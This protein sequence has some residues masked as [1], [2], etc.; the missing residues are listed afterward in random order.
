M[1]I[2]VTGAA[3]F[4]GSHLCERLLEE[5]ASVTGLDNLDPFYARE[6]KEE[7]LGILENHGGFTFHESDIR[8]PDM[9]GIVGSAKPDMIVHLAA[10]AGVRPSIE[11]PEKYIS[12]NVSGTYNLLDAARI[13][14]VGSFIF[15]SSSSVYGGNTK[16]PFSET[17]GV[18]NPVSPY[19]A[20]KKAGEL[21]CHTYHH[22]YGMDITCLRL[23]TVYGPRQRPEM[24]IYSFTEK[25]FAGEK[26]PLFSM[27]KSK[28]DYT[29]IDDIV[30]GIILSMNNMGGYR[31]Y[32]LGESKVTDLLELVSMIERATG[33]KAR[34]ELLPHQPGDMMVT[35]AD[36]SRA[37]EELGYNPKW[38][39][40]KGIEAFVDWYG[41]KRKKEA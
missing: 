15:A 22:L 13:N 23:F 38:S 34:A 20:T 4:I 24:A 7:N 39:V 29:F 12:V 16:I 2:L 30:D 1:N 11:D 27:G 18:D 35:Y 26:V 17:D 32:N 14:D 40:E 19:A 28:R 41:K 37:R 10:M 31:I 9:G 33:K 21:L 6:F 8:S 25:V 3:G 36:I 5:G